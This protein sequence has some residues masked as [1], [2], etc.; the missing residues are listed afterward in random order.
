MAPATSS[1]HSPANSLAS[2]EVDG[3]WTPEV[4]ETLIGLGAEHRVATD[5]GRDY[6]YWRWAYLAPLYELDVMGFL[7]IDTDQ[8]AFVLELSGPPERDDAPYRTW[9]APVVEFHGGS[10][11]LYVE[12]ARLLND[13]ASRINRQGDR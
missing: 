13:G 5:R 10:K 3:P 11:R 4:V 7:D 8:W 2:G 9:L 12:A 1:T 6:P